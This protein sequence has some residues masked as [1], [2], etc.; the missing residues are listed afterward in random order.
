MGIAIG[1]LHGDLN[2]E[3]T[4]RTK[5]RKKETDCMTCKYAYVTP[6]GSVTKLTRPDGSVSIQIGPSAMCMDT[7]KTKNSDMRNG[8]FICSAWEPREEK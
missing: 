8:D 1:E 7:T 3:V 5:P 4:G 6:K 2:I